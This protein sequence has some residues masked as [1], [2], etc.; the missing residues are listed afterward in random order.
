[1]CILGCDEI[2]YNNDD[3]GTFL[4]SQIINKFGSYCQCDATNM[5]SFKIKYVNQISDHRGFV[6]QCNVSAMINND[7]NTHNSNVSD[8]I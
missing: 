7:D 6:D 8:I 5:K 1:M 4:I 3:F 2:T